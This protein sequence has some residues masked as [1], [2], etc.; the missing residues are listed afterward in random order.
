MVPSNPHQ[1]TREQM[2]AIIERGESVLLPNGTIVTRKADL[3]GEAELSLLLK[4][5]QRAASAKQELRQQIAELQRKLGTMD[6]AEADVAKAREADA[7]ESA[8]KDQERLAAA[9]QA[10]LAGQ[11]Q[12]HSIQPNPAG[13]QAQTQPKGDEPPARDK[14]KGK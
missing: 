11:E 4:D 9:R 7:R 1:L 14:P 12:E 3:P 8:D 2:H 5:E 13:T 6:N 10:L